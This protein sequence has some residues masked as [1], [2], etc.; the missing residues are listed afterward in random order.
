MHVMLSIMIVREIPAEVNVLI[1]ST[2]SDNP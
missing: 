1:L 2:Y